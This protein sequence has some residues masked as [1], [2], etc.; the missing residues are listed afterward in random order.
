MTES[1][2]EI[3]GTDREIRYFKLDFGAQPWFDLWHTHVDWDGHGNEN[4]AERKKYLAQLFSCFEQLQDVA[5]D[6]LAEHQVWCIVCE[7]SREDA[8]YLHSPNPNVD[9][10]PYEFEGVYWQDEIPD[11]I[12]EF[13]DQKKMRLGKYDCNNGETIYYIKPK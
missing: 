8:V 11:L 9:N 10:F 6:N 13:F 5:A 4:S 7:D 1:R 2:D 3:G 12:V